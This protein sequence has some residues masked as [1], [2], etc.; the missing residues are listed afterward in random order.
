MTKD[1]YKI[2]KNEKLYIL[3]TRVYEDNMVFDK[4]N[5]NGVFW[6][7]EYARK[8]KEFLETVSGDGNNTHHIYEVTVGEEVE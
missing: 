1:E 4:L 3:V 5:L 2:E 7:P 8:E 6:K